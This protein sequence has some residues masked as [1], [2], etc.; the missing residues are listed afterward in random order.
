[1][2]SRLPD[3]ER[4]LSFEVVVAGD[5]SAV[6]SAWTTE[7]GVESFFAPECTVNA[8]PGGAYEMYFDP[9][10][11]PGQRGGEGNRVL[12]VQPES[13]F[14]VTWNAPPRFPAVRDQRTVVLLRFEALDSDQT[15]VRLTHVGWG[16][17][18]DWDAAYDYFDEAWGEVVLP[19]LQRRFTDGPIDWSDR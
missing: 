8:V 3:T 12:A 1:M 14:S 9:T 6:W 11:D 19:R 16:D 17:G 15:R 4:A 18:A 10:A 5:R 13:F 2:P 7:A